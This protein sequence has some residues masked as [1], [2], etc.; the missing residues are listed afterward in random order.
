MNWASSGQSRYVCAANVH[1]VMEGYDSRAF[2][3]CVNQADL[4]TPDGMPLVWILRRRSAREATR[5]YGPDLMLHL[6]EAAQQAGLPVGF[7]GSRPEVMQALLDHVH[8]RF[9][10]LQITYSYSPPFRVLS[11]DE[12][13]AIRREVT[14]S[15][16]RLLF[17]G[18]GCPKQELWMAANT[19]GVPSVMVGVGAA[20]DF[21]SHS[22]RQAPGWMRASGLEWAFR[23][24]QEPR[25]LW[26]RYLKHNTRFVMRALTDG[27]L[28][29]A[30]RNQ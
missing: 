1:M 7:F 28:L 15:G 19:H 17:V 14:Q 16:A 21:I 27:L 30:D 3:D 13:A 29:P 25:R 8:A 5:V 22:V 20:F 23:F 10:A 4:V 9:P 18:L 2:R 6:L 26:R 11:D 24:A 12:N